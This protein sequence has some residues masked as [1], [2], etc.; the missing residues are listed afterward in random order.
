MSGVDCNHPAA[1]AVQRMALN[2]PSGTIKGRY[3][4]LRN[5]LLKKESASWR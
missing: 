5:L 2:K 3:N 1:G 4:F